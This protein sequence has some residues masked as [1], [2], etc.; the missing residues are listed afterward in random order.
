M[1]MRVLWQF[2]C[3]GHPFSSVF[4]LLLAVLFALTSSSS[5]SSSS[6]SSSRRQLPRAFR[7]DM[8]VGSAEQF[9]GHWIVKSIEQGLECLLLM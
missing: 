2:Y 1:S 8:H 4:N 5:R 3:L 7:G 6:S 9:V